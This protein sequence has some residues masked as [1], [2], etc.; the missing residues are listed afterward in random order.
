MMG[1]QGLYK[2]KKSWSG[3]HHSLLVY[4][5]SKLSTVYVVKSTV[6]GLQRAFK[7]PVF[8]PSVQSSLTNY[9]GYDLPR[10]RNNIRKCTTFKEFH[11]YPKFIFNQKTIVHFHYVWMV[12]VSHNDNLKEN[13]KKKCKIYHK[14]IIQ[15]S[16]L[17]RSKDPS[18]PT[19]WPAPL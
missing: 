10:M 13:C 19:I 17:Q 9:I 12:I 1:I 7:N 14:T 5:A 8:P 2:P 6:L 18:G 3:C 11:N 15:C 16:F 4:N